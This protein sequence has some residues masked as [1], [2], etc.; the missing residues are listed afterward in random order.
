MGWTDNV[1]FLR[2]RGKESA[3]TPE[4]KGRT[5][6]VVPLYPVFKEG[7]VDSDPGPF[8]QLGID[9]HEP[10]SNGVSLSEKDARILELEAEL[11][12]YKQRERAHYLSM[13]ELTSAGSSIAHSVEMQSSR[14]ADALE[15][16]NRMG[17][18]FEDSR[19]HLFSLAEEIEDA[20]GIRDE[21]RSKLDV[22][23]DSGVLTEDKIRAMA[24]AIGSLS[25][26][27]KDVLNVLSFIDAISSTTNILS[28]NA[29]IEAAR[30]GEAGRGFAVI[31]QEI[32]NLAT[33]TKDHSTTIRERL[34]LVVETVSGLSSSM[35][36]TLES[37]Q[38]QKKAASASKE[39]FKIVAEVF[40]TVDSVSGDLNG[41]FDEVG[42][43]KDQVVSALTAISAEAEAV[44]AA[45]EEVSASMESQ[46]AGM[47]SSLA[48]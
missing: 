41:S 38:E 16:L 9:Q 30:A 35:T 4:N 43:L 42:T 2:S 25:S 37:L 13:N 12:Q 3:F 22:L 10:D 21:A 27:T 19:S 7:E 45:A 14:T 32:R 34:G 28:L 15:L 48:D 40:D 11:E 17:S 1:P 18:H 39:A 24:E 44:S 26:L 5:G 33:T 20:M 6:V 47:Q 23:Y 8:L 31:S 29:S 36:D 46:S